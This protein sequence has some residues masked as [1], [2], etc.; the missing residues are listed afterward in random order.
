MFIAILLL[1]LSLLH[2]YPACIAKVRPLYKRMNAGRRTQSHQGSRSTVLLFTSR[3][4]LKRLTAPKLPCET[5]QRRIMAEHCAA[6][7][8]GTCISHIIVLTVQIFATYTQNMWFVRLNNKL[9]ARPH[10]MPPPLYAASCSPAPAHTRLMP[11][12]L[13]VPC[14]MNIHYR[15]AAA[16]L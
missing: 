9:C 2:R 7:Y 13:S 11:A 4:A 14:S 8:T 6:I 1:V 16:R 15:Q 3:T 5:W 10:D 12:A